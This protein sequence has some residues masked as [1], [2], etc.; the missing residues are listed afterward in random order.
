MSMSRRSR[1]RGS[2]TSTCGA[3]T[4]SKGDRIATL[5][6]TD[7]AIA[8]RNAEAALAQA[9]ADLANILYDRR[10][11]ENAAIEANLKAARVQQDDAQRRLIRRKDLNS[12]G[13]VSQADL[14]AAQTAFD[15]AASRVRDLAAN[16]AVARLPA[17]DE[18][19]LSAR[20]KVAQAK[21]ALDNKRW[22]LDQH[23]L[24]APAA[25]YRFRHHPSRR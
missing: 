9:N 14:D 12:R 18:E 5:E 17:R 16:L 24:V 11:E 10:P 2:P 13:F 22:R 3:A 20:N 8:V 23:Q 25:G 6:T 1:S 7:A 21:A 15:V 19:I 4:G